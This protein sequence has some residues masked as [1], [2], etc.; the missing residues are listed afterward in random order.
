MFGCKS[1]MYRL[2]PHLFV[3]FHLFVNNSMCFVA[4]IYWLNVKS[5]AFIDHI[6]ML[7]HVPSSNVT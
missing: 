1:T 4:Y 6:P 5:Q 7:S 2:N 3:R